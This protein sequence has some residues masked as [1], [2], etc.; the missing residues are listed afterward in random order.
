LSRCGDWLLSPLSDFG[1]QLEPQQGMGSQE[2]TDWCKYAERMGYGY[3]FRS[4]HYLPIPTGVADSAECWTSL[5]MIATA[6]KTL[7]FGPMV[8]PTSYRNPALLAK[9][10]RTVNLASGGRLVFGLGAG[11]Y[12]KEYLAYGYEFPDVPTRLEQFEEALRIIIPMATGERVSFRGKHYRAEVE[13]LPKVKTY[14]LI[15]GR[16][17]RVI[18]AAARF[19][20]EWNIHGSPL[21]KV[22]RC[23]GIL[24][25]ASAGRTVKASNTAPLIIA[26]T[27][28]NLIEHV[29]DRSREGT[30]GD[31][32]AEIDSL[33][34]GG[35]FC[36]TPTEVA[37]QIGE[38]KDL[39]I[40]RFYFEV[41]DMRTK[42][43]ADLLTETLKGV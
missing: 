36:G 26:D 13:A 34:Q 32:E 18:E 21:W 42:S 4:D 20:D 1:L 31:P 41:T 28:R 33:R 30:S 39:G 10:A 24:D 6:T 9:M 37:S 12:E 16:H 11:W 29:R 17:R 25:S 14:F 22:K 19:A 40:D 7:R 35:T 5:A 2:L 38:R 8:T 27:K 43:M 15:G 23:K 3:A